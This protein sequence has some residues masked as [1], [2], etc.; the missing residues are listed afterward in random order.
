MIT[1]KKGDQGTTSL[2]DGSRV[3]K[4]DQRIELNGEL[5]ELS[6]TLGLCR[7]LLQ[8]DEPFMDIQRQLSCF[9]AVIAQK[10]RELSEGD[11]TFLQGAVDE[12]ETYIRQTSSGMPSFDF[13]LPGKSLPDAALHLAR[14]KARTCERRLVT[15][16]RQ[17][18]V[19]PLLLVYLNRLSDYLFAMTMA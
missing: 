2:A 12:M 16:S 15:L 13:V 8:R 6:A 9:M 19:P 18:A 10:E 14:T 5:D 7:A 11:A 4:D 3:S 17:C 1:T